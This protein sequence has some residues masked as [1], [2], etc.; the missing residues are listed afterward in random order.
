MWNVMQVLY[1]VSHQK[2]HSDLNGMTGCTHARA[3]N[4]HN[5]RIRSMS[6]ATLLAENQEERAYATSASYRV[7]QMHSHLHASLPVGWNLKC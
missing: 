2:L 5:G 6:L 4:A 3:M 7:L 1:V